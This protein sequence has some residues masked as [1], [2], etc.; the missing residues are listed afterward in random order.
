MIAAEN[1]NIT[2]EN[3]IVTIGNRKKLSTSS[4]FYIIIAYGALLKV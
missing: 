1:I 3:K 4:S 2:N